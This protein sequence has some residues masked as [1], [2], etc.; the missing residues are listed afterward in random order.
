MLDQTEKSD[1]LFD[2]GNNKQLN[3]VLTSG[4]NILFDKSKVRRNKT[5][6]KYI[7]KNHNEKKNYKIGYVSRK[8]KQSNIQF[9]TKKLNIS[10]DNIINKDVFHINN[11]NQNK[12]TVNDN[13]IKILNEKKPIFEISTNGHKKNE[14]LLTNSTTVTKL[15]TPDN[16]QMNNNN[17]YNNDSPLNINFFSNNIDNFNIYL[18]RSVTDSKQLCNLYDTSSEMDSDYL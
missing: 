13:N 12:N 14:N 2:K 5:A 4:E 3:D 1:L 16:L 10:N 8:K 15:K 11:N 17:S 9:Q 18:S 6:K 7:E